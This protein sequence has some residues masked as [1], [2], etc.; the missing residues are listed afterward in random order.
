VMAPALVRRCRRPRSRA[1]AKYWSWSS[2]LLVSHSRAKRGV[3]VAAVFADQ[4]GRGEL[5]GLLG[6]PAVFLFEAAGGFGFFPVL[7]VHAGNACNRE[8]G[9]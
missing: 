9:A 1:E 2:R 5:A 8:W 3:R 7:A 4:E 6:V